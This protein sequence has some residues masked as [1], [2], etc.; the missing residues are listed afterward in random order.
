MK[1]F[2]GRGDM[3]TKQKVD[4]QL[5]I[6][7]TGKIAREIVENG[8]G[9]KIIGYIETRKSKDKFCGLRVYEIGDLPEKYDY[10][11]IANTH[12]DEIY[13]ISVQYDI[14]MNKCIFLRALKKRIGLKKDEVLYDILGE[15]NYIN[16]CAEY[17]LIKNTFFERD[18]KLYRKMNTRDTFRIQEDFLYPVITDKYA[19]AGSM[20]NYFWQDLWAARLIYKSGIRSHFDIGSRIDGFIAHLL[21]MDIKVT[22]IDVRKFP[23]N[24]E[25]LYTFISDATNLLQLKDSSIESMSALCSLEHFGLGRYG[26]PIDP[27]ACFRCFKNIQAKLKSGGHLYISVPIGKERVEFNAHRVFYANTIINCFDQMKLIELSCTSEE[28]IECQIELSRYDDDLCKGNFRFGLF[29]FVKK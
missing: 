9:G 29:H 16:Y 12:T 3:D 23:G 22:L 7:G 15:K 1:K 26:D 14:D 18:M 11:I 20:S 28:G 13:K 2:I 10:I 25:N 4:Y 19:E 5:L 6:W 21:A 17:G 27:E 8:L 24:V